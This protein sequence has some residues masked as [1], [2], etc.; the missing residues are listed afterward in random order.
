MNNITFKQFLMTYNFRSAIG[1]GC[2]TENE[3]TQIIRLY[4]PTE[5][6]ENF[7]QYKWIEF[8]IY[9]FSANSLKMLIAETFLNE[10]IMNS[11]IESFFVED[12]TSIL[13]VYLTNR[14]EY[15]N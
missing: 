11:Y 3:D 12:N 14:E 5:E 1:N 8:G 4:P 13:H 7:L 2:G 10:K 6:S 15:D 9:D